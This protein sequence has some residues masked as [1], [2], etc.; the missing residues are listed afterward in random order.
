MSYPGNL[1]RL[2]GKLRLPGSKSESNRVLLLKGLY[3]NLYIENLSDSD[4]TVYMH[5][6]LNEVGETVDVHHAGTAMRFLTAYYATRSGPE[7]TITGSQRMKERP[8]GV[9]VDALRKLGGTIEYLGREGY[10][11]IRILGQEPETEQVRLNAGVSSQYISALL[12]AA[13]GFPKGIILWLDGEVTSAP[14]IEMTLSLLRQIGVECSWE[15]ERIRILPRATV[16]D[17][18]IVVESDWSA[19]SYYYSLLSLSPAGSR[20]ELEHFR[21]ESLQGDARLTHIYRSLGIRSEFNGNALVLRKEDH[22][23]DALLSLDLSDTPDIAQTIAVTCF[24]KG[25]PCYLTGLH[26]LPIKETDRLAALKREIGKLGGEI[27]TDRD[28]LR[29]SARKKPIREGVWI[30]TYDDH[31]MAMAFAP[32]GFLLPIGIRDDQVVSKSYPLFWDHLS[33]LGFT[34]ERE[35]A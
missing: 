24:A 34:T 35:E 28:S 22:E 23:E 31:R 3:P 1:N 9:L 11:P 12:L 6:G 17:Q 21:S 29:L 15:G 18:T 25:R 4:D 10:P 30:D 14:Y 26:T 16:E 13:P 33:S 32:L 19:A 8:I 5:R 27:E 7:V 20:L 2:N